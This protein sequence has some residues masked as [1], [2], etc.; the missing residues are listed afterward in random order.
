MK[1]EQA[2]ELGKQER[3]EMEHRWESALEMMAGLQAQLQAQRADLQHVQEQLPGGQEMQVMQLGP[4]WS[5]GRRAR[6][7]SFF[8][9]AERGYSGHASHPP[10]PEQS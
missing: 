8:G 3:A 10:D 6:W 7:P 2:V 5:T 9:P 1:L 4:S